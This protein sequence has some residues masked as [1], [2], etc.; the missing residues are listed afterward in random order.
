MYLAESNPISVGS[1]I[2]RSDQ[3]RSLL[4]YLALCRL[5]IS[6][7]HHLIHK[8]VDDDK[9]VSDG[10][11]F[12]FLEVLDENLGEAVEEEDDFHGVGVSLR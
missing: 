7:V 4:Q 2:P 8:L 9:V 10:L 11:F 1:G 5:G 6:K 12:E 3:P